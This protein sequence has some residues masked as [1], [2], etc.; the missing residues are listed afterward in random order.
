MPIP[1]NVSE[2]QAFLGLANYYR[3]FISN[4]HMLRAP[5]NKLLRKD[6]KRNCSKEYQKAFEQMKKILTWDL[7]LMYFNPKKDIIVVIIL[8]HFYCKWMICKTKKQNDTNTPS[9]QADDKQKKSE[10]Y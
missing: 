6:K 10:W 5:L 2:L 7:S 9:M 4:M 8:T 1:T 3:N